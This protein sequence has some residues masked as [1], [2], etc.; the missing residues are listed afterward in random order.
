MS[1]NDDWEELRRG[2]KKTHFVDDRW[3]KKKNAN[4]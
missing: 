2:K 4:G 1:Q 3:K